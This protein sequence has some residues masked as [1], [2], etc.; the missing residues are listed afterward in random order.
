ML[1][2]ARILFVICFGIV[3]LLIGYLI[4]EKYL[5]LRAA[6]CVPND[7]DAYVYSPERLLTLSLCLRVTGV[8]MNLESDANDGDAFFDLNVDPPY[9]DLLNAMNSRNTG[10]YFH[11]EIPCYANPTDF[12]PA[13]VCPIDPDPYRGALPKIGQR[14]WAEGRWVWDLN[15]G[16]HA[17]LHPL[18]RWSEIE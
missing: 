2:I 11:L 10:G 15:H 3:L 13:Q 9:G 16:G 5:P 14:I 8:V 1:R 7:Q 6:N 12:I 18:Y 4:P 17:E